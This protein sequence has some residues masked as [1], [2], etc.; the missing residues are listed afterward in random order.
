MRLMILA[1]ALVLLSASFGSAQCLAG[2]CPARSVA[3]S[4]VSAPVRTVKV[5]KER[6][7]FH[8]LRSRCR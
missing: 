2:N 7:R 4:V 3:R 8:V 1:L 6:K 5:L